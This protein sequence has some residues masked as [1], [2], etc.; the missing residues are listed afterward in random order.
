M[1]K[2]ICITTYPPR[3]CGIATFSYDLIETIHKKFGQ[4]LT[5][6]VCA[7]E[8]TIEKHTYDDTVEYTLN[9]SEKEDFT[10][11]AKRIN[12]DSDVNLVCIEHAACPYFS[13]I[14]K[15]AATKHTTSLSTANASSCSFPA[16]K[17]P[18]DCPCDW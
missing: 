6:K 15:T 18:K 8:S 1:K 16:A 12:Q 4:N 10:V 17:I 14:W 13:N 5:I 3:V 11:V 9:S 7:V 2:I